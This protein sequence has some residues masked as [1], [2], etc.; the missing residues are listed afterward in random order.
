L[1]TGVI[2]EHA[3]FYVRRKKVDEIKPVSEG[4]CRLLVVRR[5]EFEMVLGILK[6]KV[7]FQGYGYTTS[8]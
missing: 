6:N 4:P 3:F 8:P 5:W 2:A 7:A 1:L